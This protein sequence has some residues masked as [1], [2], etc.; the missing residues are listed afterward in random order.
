MTLV[1]Q[2]DWSLAVQEQAA[3]RF[4]SAVIRRQLP[5]ATPIAV[6]L[7][8]E[9]D[10]RLRIQIKPLRELRRLSVSFALPNVDSCYPSNR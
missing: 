10:L 2:S 4:F 1:I 7:Y 9:Q 8:R 5:S 6:P 3:K